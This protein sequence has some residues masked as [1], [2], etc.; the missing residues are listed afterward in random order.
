MIDRHLVLEGFGVRLEPLAVH[1]LSALRKACSDQRLWQLVFSLNPFV[2]DTSALAWFEAAIGD[3]RCV[4][5]AIVDS[6]TGEVMG[7]TRY[8]DVEPA[9]RK[10]EIGWTFLAPCYWRTHVNTACKRLLLQHAFETLQCNRVQ[11][12]AEAINMRSRNAIARLGATHEGTLRNFRIREGGEVRDT[13]FY[14]IIAS[15]WPS[16][17][18][19]LEARLR[20]SPFVEVLVGPG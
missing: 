10:L 7:S 16:V 19:G 11:F 3:A 15:E 18:E 4:P 2:D 17:K 20:Q 13:S 8:L 14:S 9:H 5:F 1:H 12:K 6:T